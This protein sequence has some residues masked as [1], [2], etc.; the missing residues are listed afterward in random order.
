MDNVKEQ[1][2]D[3]ELRREKFWS[4]IN[5]EIKIERLRKEVKSLQRRLE[6]TFGIVSKLVEHDHKDGRIMIDIGRILGLVT[7]LSSNQ[8]GD[9][10]YF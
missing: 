6:E 4:E 2:E 8:D 9:D 7:K 3:K 1:F 10:V 5:Q